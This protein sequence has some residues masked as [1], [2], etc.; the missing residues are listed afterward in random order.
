MVNIDGSPTLV[1]DIFRRVSA[2]KFAKNW[3]DLVTMTIPEGFTPEQ[4]AHRLYDDPEY[5]WV[6]L[7]VNDIVD[8]REEWP[9]DSKT[10]VAYCKQKYGINGMYEV[11]HYRTTDKNK[12]IVDYDPVALSNGTIE[13]VTNFIYEDEI[14]NSKREIKVVPVEHLPFFVNTYRGLIR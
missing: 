10:L 12:F 5:H 13:P 3:V 2:N 9:R 7:I 8:V 6:F 4:L 1:T 11:H 14:N